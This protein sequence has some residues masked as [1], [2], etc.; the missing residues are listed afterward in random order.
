MSG[1]P[2]W[3]RLA[4]CQAFPELPWLADRDDVTS[5]DRL[6]LAAACRACGC[7]ERCAEFVG[8]EH[9]DGGFWAGEFRDLPTLTTD[10]EFDGAA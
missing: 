9:I 5:R 4:V 10:T 8:R 3:M 2:E 7:V 1:T 6:R